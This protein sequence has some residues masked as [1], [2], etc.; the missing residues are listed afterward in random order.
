VGAVTGALAAVRLRL[1]P[2]G[3]AL[4]PS[5]RLQRRVMTLLA[6][7]AVFAAAYMLYLRDSGLVAVKQV[8]V[9]GL[10]GEAA[11]EVRAALDRV[12]RDSTTLHVDRAAIEQVAARFPAIESVVITPDFPNSMGIRVIEHRPAALLALGERKVA[13]AGDGSVLTDLDVKG[14]LPTI[15]I[16]GGFPARALEPGPALDAVRV[17]GGAP[18]VI[19]ARLEKIGRERGRGVVV[20]VKDGP[21]LVFGD[22]SRIAAKWGAALRVLADRDAAGAE[23]VDVRIP[24]RPAAGG[25]PVETVAPV[26]PAGPDQPAPTQEGAAA[27]TPATPAAPQPEAPQTQATPAQPEPSAP[28]AAPGGTAAPNL[29]P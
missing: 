19:T 11:N 16:E 22:A 13:V 25:L 24:E 8:T 3:R 1:A 9:T 14:S 7:S 28:P 12:A 21:E 2:W 10:T 4:K 27:A 18:A 23:Y 29:Q 20:H 6:A 17:A 15:A 26:A 5:P